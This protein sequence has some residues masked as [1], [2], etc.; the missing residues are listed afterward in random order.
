LCNHKFGAVPGAGKGDESPFLEVTL[1]RVV[2]SERVLD[3]LAR[4]TNEWLA[5]RGNVGGSSVSRLVPE[6]VGGRSRLLQRNSLAYAT[7]PASPMGR[8]RMASWR[9]PRVRKRSAHPVPRC[10]CGVR[11]GSGHSPEPG[12]TPRRVE[13]AFWGRPPDPVAH[14]T[15]HMIPPP[16]GGSGPFR[17][18][19]TRRFRNR[20]RKTDLPAT[21]SGP[22]RFIRQGPVPTR[23]SSGAP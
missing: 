5:R 8:L 20:R 14:A 2:A 22:N 9:E 23:C 7:D 4:F 12:R 13:N 15:D 6:T 17:G 1:C 19:T 21:A 16:D 11:P 10:R 3:P 18:A